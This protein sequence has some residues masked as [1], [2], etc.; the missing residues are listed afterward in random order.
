MAGEKGITKFFSLTH[1]KWITSCSW[2]WRKVC[3]EPWL[4]KHS[5]NVASESWGK[6]LSEP[7]WFCMGRSSDIFSK[8]TALTLKLMIWQ[9]SVVFSHGNSWFLCYRVATD[10]N[11]RERGCK[12]KTHCDPEDINSKDPLTF[13]WHKPS[14]ACRPVLLSGVQC[15]HG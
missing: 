11:R 13:W 6:E 4:S 2:N 10:W 5:S 3:L 12:K 9:L 1:C 15:Y 7:L 8:T 14:G